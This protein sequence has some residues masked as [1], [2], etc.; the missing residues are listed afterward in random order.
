MKYDYHEELDEPR[1]MMEDLRSLCHN[2]N[3]MSMAAKR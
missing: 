3:T 1:S 2:G